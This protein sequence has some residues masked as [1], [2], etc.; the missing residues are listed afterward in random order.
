MVAA[1]RRTTTHEVFIDVA[2]LSHWDW[3]KYVIKL[4]NIFYIYIE[5]STMQT[6]V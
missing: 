3:T 5:N 2:T 6:F 1:N 4:K